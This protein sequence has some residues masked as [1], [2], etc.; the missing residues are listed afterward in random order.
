M[1][2]RAL[3]AWL[4]SNG[5]RVVVKDELELNNLKILASI[6]GFIGTTQKGRIHF[7]SMPVYY[8]GELEQIQKRD[9]AF[10]NFRTDE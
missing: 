8:E 2:D 6:H 4:A 1:T 9:E 5:A 7:L 3:G 10:T